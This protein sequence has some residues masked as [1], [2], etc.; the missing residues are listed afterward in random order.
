MGVF[1]VHALVPS[2][3]R[4]FRAASEVYLMHQPVLKCFWQDSAAEDD[5]RASPAPHPDF[6]DCRHRPSDRQAES[7]LPAAK[8][9]HF[10]S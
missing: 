8:L 7:L 1:R 10:N 9:R 4:F 5:F 3:R 2:N 6:T